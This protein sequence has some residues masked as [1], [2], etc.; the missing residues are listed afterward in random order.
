V[1]TDPAAELDALVE[2]VR[3]ALG[4]SR[5]AASDGPFT[6]A[7]LDG[8]V[9]VEVDAAGRLA[10][11]ELDPKVLREPLE[12]IAAAIVSAVNA[13]LDSRPAPPDTGALSAQ[14]QRVQ[15]ESVAQMAR[16]TEAFSEALARTQA[17]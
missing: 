16:I 10:H 7:A 4:G 13:A 15:Q 1:A 2:Q 14:L 8:R 6:G 17:R 11:L 3:T 9:H 5:P 12:Q